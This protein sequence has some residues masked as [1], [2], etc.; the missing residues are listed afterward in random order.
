MEI[1]N[2]TWPIVIPYIDIYN[3]Q[4]NKN[5]VLYISIADVYLNYGI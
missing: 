3:L 1:E 4:I 2:D 5:Q